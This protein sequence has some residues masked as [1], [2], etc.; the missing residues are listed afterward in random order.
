MNP[1][2]MILIG[3]V[4]YFGSSNQKTVVIK[5]G[6][7]SHNVDVDMVCRGMKTVY[8]NQNAPSLTCIIDYSTLAHFLDYT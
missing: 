1:G 4:Q 8:E 3:S 2:S 5:L 7:S 6:L